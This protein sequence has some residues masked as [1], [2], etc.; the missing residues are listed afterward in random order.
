[1][2]SAGSKEGWSD[3]I[4]RTDKGVSEL[5]TKGYLRSIE[6]DNL[7]CIKETAKGK[8]KRAEK[9]IHIRCNDS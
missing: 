5:E 7:D 2:S 3:V 8:S 9:M 6:I 4:I 1:M